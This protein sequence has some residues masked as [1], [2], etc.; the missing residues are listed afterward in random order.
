M[1]IQKNTTS[2]HTVWK[3]RGQ[4]YRVYTCVW[5]V[6]TG[7]VWLSPFSLYSV[8]VRKG[9]SFFTFILFYILFYCSTF[10]NHTSPWVSQ[11]K[12]I[13]G[14]WFCTVPWNIGKKNYVACHVSLV[15]AFFTQYTNQTKLHLYRNSPEYIHTDLF[16]LQRATQFMM[17]NCLTSKLHDS[18]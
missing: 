2:L 12:N 8:H 7:Y 16:N 6:G 9:I 11:M 10:A 13:T 3:N 4:L 14:L 17:H 1:K 5:R 18:K 15:T